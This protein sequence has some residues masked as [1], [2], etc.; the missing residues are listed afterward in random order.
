M[1]RHGGY[2][3]VENKDGEY[4][5]HDAIHANGMKM[6]VASN[7]DGDDWM[8]MT[9]PSAEHEVAFVDD[10]F[11]IMHE[12]MDEAITYAHAARAV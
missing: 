3:W 10:G 9:A 7:R 8:Y 2:E 11:A 1:Y 12:A 4:N 5:Q 6:A